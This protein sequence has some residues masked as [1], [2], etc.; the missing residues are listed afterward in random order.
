[1]GRFF[2]SCPRK[3]GTPRIETVPKSVGVPRL[4]SLFAATKQQMDDGRSRARWDRYVWKGSEHE[5]PAAE[6]ERKKK[7]KTEEPVRDRIKTALL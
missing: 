3:R 1:L 6:N 7:F 5:S 4:T 2:V